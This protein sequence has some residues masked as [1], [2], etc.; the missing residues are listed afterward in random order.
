VLEEHIFLKEEDVMVSNVRLVIEDE[1][2]NDHTYPISG[3]SSVSLLRG[4]KK[5][6]MIRAAIGLI[7]ILSSVLV[8]V[9]GSPLK[10]IG[11]ILGIVIIATAVQKIPHSV[12]IRT[13]A[14]DTELYTDEDPELISRVYTALND[15]IIFRG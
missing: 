12:Q 7:T 9:G 10:I 3:I 14:G 5:I 6:H 11:F 15:A 2:E 8:Q 1:H 4:K 13:S